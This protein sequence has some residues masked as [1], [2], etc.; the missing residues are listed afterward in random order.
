MESLMVAFILL[1]TAV[2]FIMSIIDIYRHD[3]FSNQVRLNLTVLVFFFPILGPVLY[4]SF[5]KKK[6]TKKYPIKRV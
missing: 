4:Y 1:V 6:Y 3:K 2:T 5:F